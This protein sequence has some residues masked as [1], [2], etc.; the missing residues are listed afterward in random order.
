M[1]A[2]NMLARKTTGNEDR[3][4]IFRKQKDIRLQENAEGVGA[5]RHRNQRVSRSK[6]D[7]EERLL[8][9]NMHEV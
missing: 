7:E 2:E 9:S 4:A 1:P 3:K 8:S 6:D 5:D